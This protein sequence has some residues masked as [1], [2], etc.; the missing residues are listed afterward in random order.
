MDLFTLKEGDLIDLPSFKERAAKNVIAAIDAARKVPLHRLLVALSID[1]VGEETARLIAEEFKTI[2]RIEKATEEELARI[3]GVGDIVAA[4]LAS[5]MENKQNRKTLHELLQYV[6]IEMPQEA[7]NK[8]AL[9]GK[10]IVFTGTL[11]TVGRD[12]AAQRAR[13]AGAHVTNSVTKKTD[14][15]VAG[16]NPGSKIEKAASLGVTVLT[17]EEF[18]ALLS[19]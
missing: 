16:E 5:W 12:E 15:V 19:E 10:T 1:H 2:E 11:E 7:K 17:E 4:S 9:T 13:S 18:K 8:T 3:H 6:D 14:Y